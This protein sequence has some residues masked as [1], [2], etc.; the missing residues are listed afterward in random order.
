MGKQCRFTC[1]V[2]KNINYVLTWNGLKNL[3]PGATTLK[4]QVTKIKSKYKRVNQFT[5]LNSL[6][7][8][9]IMLKVSVGM[10]AHIAS[11]DNKL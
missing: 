3:L 5:V 9:F 8:S 11:Y 2:Y 1:S 7:L 6:N 4:I 10:A